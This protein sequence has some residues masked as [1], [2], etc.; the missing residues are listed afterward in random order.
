MKMTKKLL[1]TGS[2]V[3]LAGGVAGACVGTAGGDGAAARHG[4]PPHALPAQ[5]VDTQRNDTC[6]QEC[7][8]LKEQYSLDHPSDPNVDPL[9]SFRIINS[10]SFE[11]EV[12]VD[13]AD[14]AQYCVNNIE[15]WTSD[16]RD[17]SNI[18]IKAGSAYADVTGF[19][20]VGKTSK[21]LHL[22]VNTNDNPRRCLR[23]DGDTEAFFRF[24]VVDDCEG[25]DM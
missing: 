19:A 10:G 13:N 3:A 8:S 15:G 20:H 1:I 21:P 16:V 14:P 18:H 24:I 23:L 7:G 5:R 22:V 11:G 6:H 25:F 4:V 2:A 12:C 17:V 9:F